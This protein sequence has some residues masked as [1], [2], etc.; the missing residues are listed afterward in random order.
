ME[1]MYYQHELKH[2]FRWEY[3]SGIEKKKKRFF[4]H[5]VDKPFLGDVRTK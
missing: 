2:F 5:Q 4:L 3:L 1:Y